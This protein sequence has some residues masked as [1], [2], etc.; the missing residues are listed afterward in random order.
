MERDADRGTRRSLERGSDRAGP[1]TPRQ[2]E[3]ARNVARGC[4]NKEIAM[5][6]GIAEQTV[7]DHVSAIC[8]RL[9]LPNRA[10][11]AAWVIQRDDLARGYPLLS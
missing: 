7:K 3:I 5:R 6:L 2:D 4:A 11:L 8:R 10:A 9:H 1:L